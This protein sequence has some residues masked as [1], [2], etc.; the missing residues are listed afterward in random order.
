VGSGRRRVRLISASA[1]RSK[2]WLN[3]AAEPAAS[4]MPKVAYRKVTNGRKPGVERNMPTTAVKTISA[5]TRG[6][7]SSKYSRARARVLRGVRA[8]ARERVEA[9]VCV[10]IYRK[11]AARAGHDRALPMS[12]A[13]TPLPRCGRRRQAGKDR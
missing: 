4:A 13:G 6:F 12:A 11:R 10:F 1:A 2:I 7:V 5:T 3:V 9:D 8:A